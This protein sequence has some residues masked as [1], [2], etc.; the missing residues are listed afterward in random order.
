MIDDKLN[1]KKILIIK[2]RG[3]GDVVLSTIILDSLKHNFPNAHIDY[4]VDSPSDQF[5]KPLEIVDETIV[6]KKK[7]LTQKIKLFQKV[8]NNKY[9]II[10]DFFANPFSAQLTYYSGAKYRAGFPYK[11][12]KYAYN[13]IGPEERNKFHAAELHLEMLRLINL[14]LENK[15]LYF[16][17]PQKD[18]SFANNYFSSYFSSDDNVIAISPSGGWASKKC[19]PNVFAQIADEIV[20]R[21]KVK[22]LI[23][24]GP[25]DKLEAEEITN[26]MNGNFTLAPKTSITEM[27]AIIKNCK[28]LIANDSGPM[29]ISTAVGTATLSLHGPT[30][31]HL[32]GPFGAKHTWV[33]NELLDCIECNLLE[34]NKNHEC[35]TE[36]NVNFVLDKFEELKTKNNLW[37]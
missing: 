34:C 13:L 2:F 30:S 23:L 9:D 21:Y 1:I 4:L 8:R 36:L 32:Q 31:P 15:F 33:R 28:I 6:Y 12:R 25:E 3:I 5:L 14:E 24:W 27:G 35:F 19:E 17:I 11:G 26:K 37:I 29:H 18:L 7:G 10:F 22:I 20:K 16:G